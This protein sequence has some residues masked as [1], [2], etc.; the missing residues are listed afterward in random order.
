MFE[1]LASCSAFRCST[2]LNMTGQVFEVWHWNFQSRQ[3]RR[4][5]IQS[6]WQKRCCPCDL[7]RAVQLAT[8]GGEIDWNLLRRSWSWPFWP[9]LWALVLVL[10]GKRL[11]PQAQGQ[12]VTRS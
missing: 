5:Y 7:T 4:P 12:P 3:H 6:T 1:S 10:K 2:S 9:L 11:S 8:K